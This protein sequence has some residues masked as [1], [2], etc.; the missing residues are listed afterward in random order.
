M[1]IKFF[2]LHEGLKYGPGKLVMATDVEG[3]NDWNGLSPEQKVDL[4]TEAKSAF[5]A[6]L[7]EGT[8]ERHKGAFDVKF[9]YE[10]EKNDT[11]RLT[12]GWWWDL[13][14]DPLSFYRRTGFEVYYP[15]TGEKLVR[16]ELLTGKSRRPEGE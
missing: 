11:N 4:M 12:V 7:H 10:V 2:Y 8:E 5:E 1:S 6:P 16:E 13:S 14:E 3:L 9:V 15:S